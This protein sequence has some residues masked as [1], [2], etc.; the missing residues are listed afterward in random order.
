MAGF[1]SKIWGF[2]SGIYPRYLRSHFGMDI[3]ENVIIARTVHLDKNIN[4]KGIHIGDN[5]WLLR[6][7]MVLAHDYCRGE[8][9]TGKRYQTYIGRNC[10]IG[11]NSIIL[12]G[13]RIG[14]HCVVAAGSVVTKDV[15]SHCIVAGNPAKVQK[16]GV[17]VSDDGQI[18]NDGQR[19]E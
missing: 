11:V 10:V 9:G 2:W 6:N 16:T 1:R 13:V 8:N 19:V 18:L 17:E 3:G 14:D 7:A 4:P 12:P 5:T 15:P